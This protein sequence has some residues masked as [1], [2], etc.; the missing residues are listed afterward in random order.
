M[1]LCLLKYHNFYI[2][3]FKS[4]FFSCLIPLVAF[5]LFHPQS[6][7]MT[8]YVK[9]Y[10]DENSLWIQSLYWY[11]LKSKKGPSKKHDILGTKWLNWIFFKKKISVNILLA[12]VDEKRTLVLLEDFDGQ[13]FLI[14]IMTF[15]FWYLDLRR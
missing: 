7:N 11:E 10:M 1:F 13:N 2:S 3:P 15:F 4:F 5:Y 12:R 8:F 9:I 6:I 14:I